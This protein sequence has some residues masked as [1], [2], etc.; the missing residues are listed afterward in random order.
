MNGIRERRRD[1]QPEQRAGAEQ[2]RSV[3]QQPSGRDRVWIDQRRRDRGVQQRHH[4]DEREQRQRAL[5]KQ[6]GE[7]ESIV[8]I[9]NRQHERQ[10]RVMSD[11]L[12][13]PRILVGRPSVETQVQRRHR[14]RRQRDRCDA[15]LKARPAGAR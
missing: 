8:L 9:E 10:R 4:A 3:I 2:V 7:R 11:Q 15:S 14:E 6:I 5:E 12:D 1:P 13:P